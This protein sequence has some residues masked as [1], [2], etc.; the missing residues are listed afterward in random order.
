MNDTWLDNVFTVK[1]PV[2][3]MLHLA[4]LPGDPGYDSV[5]GISAI[6]D[7]A[8]GELE[9][10]QEGGVDGVMVSNEFSLP[11]LTKTEPITAI[12]MARIITELLPELSVPHG[13]NVLWDG[14]ASIDLAVATGAQWVR[15]IF[16]GV[17]ASDFGLWNT[18]VGEV[19]RYRH[20]IGAH[21][22]KLLF[23]IVPES[24]AYAADRSLQSIAR[25]TVFATA[26]DALCVSGLTAGSPTDTQSLTTVKDAAG[27]VPVF[28]NTGVEASNAAEQLAVADGAVVGTAFKKDGEFANRVELGRVRELMGAVRDFR[29]TA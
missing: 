13:V 17:Y 3:A 24:A 6:V 12:T 2:I 1:K 8:K 5:A 29:A 26:P 4:A 9:A 20:R 25:S 14:R 11:Y 21:D 18:N 28:V 19:A 16:T 22:V 23:N 7:R 15:E 10:L 27:S